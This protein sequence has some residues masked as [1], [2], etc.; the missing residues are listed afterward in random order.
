MGLDEC[1]KRAWIEEHQ[2]FFYRADN[3]TGAAPG[4]NL[5]VAP[6]FAWVYLQTGDITYRDRGDK[7]FAGGVRGAYLDG[8]KQF[9]QNY[10]WSFDYVKWR[11]EAA[12]GPTGLT[13]PGLPSPAVGGLGAGVAKPPMAPGVKEQRPRLPEGTGLAAK[14]PGDVGIERDPAVLFAESFEKGSLEEIG[15]RWGNLSNKDGKVIAFCDDVPP[16]STGK[17]SLQMTATLGQNTG[18]HLYTRLVRGVDTAF[19]RLYVKF[20]AE[21]FAFPCGV[22]FVGHNPPTAWPQG[23]PGRPHGDERMMVEF[24]PVSESGKHA[25]PGVWGI[26]GFWSEMKA[27]ADGNYWGNLLSPARP[28]PVASDRWQCLEVMLKCNSAPEKSDLPAAT[29]A[30]A[31]GELALWL[32][33]RLQM[34]I[35]PGVRRG[36]WSG[37]GFSLVE[38]GGSPREILRQGGEGALGNAVISRGEAFEGFR[39]RTSTDLKVNFF[40][41]LHNVTEAAMRQNKV[42]VSRVWFD[43]IVVSTAYI[44]PIQEPTHKPKYSQ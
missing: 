41:L 21:Q 29:A 5:L 27:S 14:Y 1:W 43:D 6:A 7:V 9:S 15:R 33:G 2:A 25:P 44:G 17:R 39:W 22:H 11:T 35:K 42:T 20:D 24:G 23:N 36:P 16:G 10:R 28:M 34:H 30:Q 4:L 38:Q 3:P 19:V 32:D 8:G 37:M 18:G 40:W 13:V 26:S 12:G 31:D